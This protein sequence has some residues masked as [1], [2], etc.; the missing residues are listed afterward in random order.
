MCLSCPL[1][2]PAVC[3]AEPLVS[4][5]KP[6]VSASG[7]PEGHQPAAG[8][9]PASSR[10]RDAAGALSA[11]GPAEAEL[12]PRVSAPL[13]TLC[14]GVCA[15]TDGVLVCRV[16]RCTLTSIPQTQSLLNKAKL[17]LGL[18]L[19]PFK[20]LSVSLYISPL[21]HPNRFSFRT[22]SKFPKTRCSMRC[23]H[24]HSA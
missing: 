21:L 14:C 9:E 15:L 10:S 6:A 24:F 22:D 11:A 13:S 18:L 20:D 7:G 3:S 5:V 8:A 16:F 2:C 23:V 1:T 17:P 4:G 12:Q 19:H